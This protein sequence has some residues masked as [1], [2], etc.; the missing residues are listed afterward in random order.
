MHLDPNKM[1]RAQKL[2]FLST[3][4]AGKIDIASLEQEA[5]YFCLPSNET[6][7][8]WLVITSHNTTEMN[9]EQYKAF[10]KRGGWDE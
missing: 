7:G 6:P 4:Q 10:C 2:Q 1:T 3:V 8:N 5:T 9:P